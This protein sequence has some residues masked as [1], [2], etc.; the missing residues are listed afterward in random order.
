VSLPLLFPLFVKI[1]LVRFLSEKM[2]GV[3]AY[4][5]GSKLLS[6]HGKEIDAPAYFLQDLPPVQLDGELWM[7]RGSYEKVMAL[8][9]SKSNE[10][11]WSKVR[12][13]VFDL[14]ST[15][16]ADFQGRHAQLQGLKLPSHVNIVAQVRSLS[17]DHLNGYLYSIVEGGGEGLVA[18]DPQ[19]LFNPGIITP[20][21]LK[22]KVEKQ[23]DFF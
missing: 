21:I 4:W 9:K 11:G 12:Y 16:T 22:I 23:T 3:R 13:Y 1:F 10:E 6:R 8:L 18:R 2:D 19:A 7:G 14:P 15:S 5:D 20:S 17:T